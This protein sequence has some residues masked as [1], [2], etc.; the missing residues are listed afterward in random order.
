MNFIY[1]VGLFLSTLIVLSNFLPP[2]VLKPNRI[3]DG[4]P[5]FF[6]EVLSFEYKTIFIIFV[7]ILIIIQSI[8]C[9]FYYKFF[10]CLFFLSFYLYTISFIS[11]L[12][13]EDASL[14]AR[15]SFS[16]GFWI[17]VFCLS[18]LFIDFSSTKSINFRFFIF[19]FISIYLFAFLKLGFL[20]HLSLMKEFYT[21]KDNFL[22]HVFLHIKLALGSM[23][24]AFF[25]GIPF[26]ILSHKYTFCKKIIFSSFNIFQ[27]IPSLAIFGFLIWF[28]SFLTDKYPSLKNLGI[29]GIGFAPAFIALVIYSI[30][31]LIYN[32][33]IGLE[34]VSSSVIESGMGMGMNSFQVLTKIKF[35]LA[36]PVILAGVRIVLIQNIG[37][38]VVAGLIGGGGMGSYVFQGLGQNAVDLI[39]LGVIPTLFFGIFCLYFYELCNR[40]F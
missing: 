32:I 31:P 20:D 34:K 28:L 25:I 2:L 4:N 19:L 8:K 17:C 23:F 18:M 14:F 24:T 39:L 5:I 6:Y 38:V 22:M 11:E 21:Q 36:L 9:N 40:I 3:L 35:P 15:V 10:S 16:S 7:L 13:L 26:G 30:F 33:Y 29:E 1:K 27:T 12:L 37:L